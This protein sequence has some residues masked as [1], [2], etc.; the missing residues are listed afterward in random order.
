MQRLGRLSWYEEELRHRVGYSPAD[1]DQCYRNHEGLARR[2]VAVACACCVRGANDTRAKDLPRGRVVKDDNSW[3]SSAGRRSI[4]TPCSTCW[5]RARRGVTGD[6]LA[7]IARP[8]PTR[9]HLP[10]YC[11]R[12]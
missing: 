5:T 2:A 6:L 3:T 4:A 11:R 8:M 10:S 12:R 7:I 9:S 1:P